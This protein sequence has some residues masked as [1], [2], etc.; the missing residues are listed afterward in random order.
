MAADSHALRL[1]L[2]A[3]ALGPSASATS[4]ARLGRGAAGKP[5]DASA[6]Q[7]GSEQPLFPSDS[8]PFRDASRAARIISAIRRRTDGSPTC[9]NLGRGVGPIRIADPIRSANGVSRNATEG[10]LGRRRAIFGA[11]S[12]RFRRASCAAARGRPCIPRGTQRSLRRAHCAG[13]QARD[14]RCD[15]RLCGTAA[16]RGRSDTRRAR[17]LGDVAGLSR[18][19]RVSAVDETEHRGAQRSPDRLR[20]NT[21]Q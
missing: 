9:A 3:V 13:Q 10:K 12:G 5:A 7:C 6:G 4:T 18:G 2:R 14:Q 17:P 16:R 21:R 11:T 20:R 1:G 19:R 8:A 15:D